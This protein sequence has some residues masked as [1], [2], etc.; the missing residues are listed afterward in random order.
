[1]KILVIIGAFMSMLFGAYINA[2][3]N[4]DNDYENQ[5]ISTTHNDVSSDMNLTE[6]ASASSWRGW[7]GRGWGGWGRWGRAFPYPYYGGAYGVPV[8]PAV[9]VQELPPITTHEIAPY[10]VIKSVRQDRIR[11]IHPQPHERIQVLPGVERTVIGAPVSGAP[12]QGAPMM[13]GSGQGQPGGQMPMGGGQ[14]GQGQ[15]MPMG[16]QQ[17]Q[18]TMPNGGN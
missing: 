17:G 13:E 9:P 7:R 4:S 8:A 5:Q 18:P 11:V 16:G 6:D 1:M 3:D 2:C 15:Q 10:E 12:Q 14:Q